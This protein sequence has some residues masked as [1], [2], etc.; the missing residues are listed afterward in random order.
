MTDQNL[1]VRF[2]A[3]LREEL[4]TESLLITFYSFI[5]L[6][7]FFVCSSQVVMRL[8]KFGFN[9][10]GLGNQIDGTVVFSH[11]MSDHTKQM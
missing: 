1:T 9:V 2:F 8:R 7:Q 5:Q 11:L 10:E 6:S 4:D 3:R